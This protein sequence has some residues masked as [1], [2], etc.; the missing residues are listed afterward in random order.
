MC[1][2]HII[3]RAKV[4]RTTS[5]STMQS[6]SDLRD[7][8]ASYGDKAK[9]THDMLVHGTNSHWRTPAALN[10]LT[11]DTANIDDKE[12]DAGE[13]RRRLSSDEGLISYRSTDRGI[14]SGGISSG[15]SPPMK[16]LFLTGALIAEQGRRSLTTV[17]S[18]GEQR[19]P[20]FPE[21]HN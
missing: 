17:T 14:S 11:E 4:R 7:Q 6:Q 18:R 10:I 13:K 12:V 21:L 8:E 2:R 16:V 9:I 19:P 5:S 1:R 15:D 3:A 20:A